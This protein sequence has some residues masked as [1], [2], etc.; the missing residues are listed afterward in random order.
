[1][2]APHLKSILDEVED[3]IAN[4]D[5]ERRTHAIRQLAEHAAHFA[6]AP[7]II[8]NGQVDPAFIAEARPWLDAMALWGKALASTAAGLAAA[9]QANSA[10]TGHFEQAEKYAAEATAI[11][12][13]P[14]ATRFEGPIK[15]A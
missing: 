10:A 3:A 5:A 9:N 2:Q 7:T 8:R 4:G 11:Q 14:G 6:D 1:E 12:S 15:V 13:I